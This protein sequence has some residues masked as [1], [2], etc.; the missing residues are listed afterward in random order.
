[1]GLGFDSL[2]PSEIPSYGG[3]VVLTTRA[4]A[5]GAAAVPM[6]HEEVHGRRHAVIA[7]LILQKIDPGLERAELVMGID[8]GRLTGLSV[9]YY[10]REIESSLHSS[11]AGLASHAAC[12]MSEL[13]ASSVA[14][15]IGGGD[16]RA[17]VEIGALLRRTAGRGFD[18]EMVDERGTSP[19]TKNLN[20]RGKRDRLSARS[21]SLRGR[22]ALAA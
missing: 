6:L 20:Q 5:P 7:G 9:S 16:M 14:V 4:E 13:G 1:M 3:D 12:I 18:L 10:G 19:R 17:A 2:L 8:P 15:R 22:A 11:A 21:I